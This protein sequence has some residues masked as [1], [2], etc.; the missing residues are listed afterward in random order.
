MFSACLGDSK[1]VYMSNIFVI[2][3]Q[4]FTSTRILIIA[5]CRFPLNSLKLVLAI[6]KECDCGMFQ[7]LIN[8]TT[9]FEREIAAVGVDS[10]MGGGAML[11]CCHTLATV[12]A[13]R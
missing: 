7:M 6:K 3:K 12:I 2:F 13:F 11:E 8:Y 4:I 5:I 1:K 10:N 9:F